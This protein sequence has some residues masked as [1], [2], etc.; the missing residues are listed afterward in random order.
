MK[1]RQLTLFVLIC[2]SPIAYAERPVDGRLT[3]AGVVRLWDKSDEALG[4]ATAWISSAVNTEIMF[5]NMLLAKSTVQMGL[6][7]RVDPICIPPNE[8]IG[9]VAGE[10][11]SLFRSNPRY[12]EGVSATISIHKALRQLYKCTG[13]ID[14]RK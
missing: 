11:V 6:P 8:D 13:D 10:I 7:N 1:M 2:L 14:S 4:L 5:S 3:A 12:Y 9:S